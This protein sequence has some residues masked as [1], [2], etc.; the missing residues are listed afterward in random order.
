MTSFMNSDVKLFLS[1]QISDL[2]KH[3]VW[4]V[5]IDNEA[6]EVSVFPVADVPVLDLTGRIIG[7]TV[8]LANGQS[9]WAILSYLDTQDAR[10]SEL[11]L[12]LN[13]EKNGAWFA[14]A[15]YWD[16]DRE[17]R[18]PEAIARFLGLQV[19]E[20]F[21]IAYDVTKYA[22]GERS[23]LVGVVPREPREKLPRDE[24]IRLA[25]P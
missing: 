17:E 9:V 7:T 22:Q 25:V 4:E 3:P 5:I 18:G 20:V 10:K 19:D 24:I 15:R 13:L 12:L 23:A 21:P 2:E 14:L 6:E 16:V 11:F 1:L 8:R